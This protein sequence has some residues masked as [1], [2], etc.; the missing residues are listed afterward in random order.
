MLSLETLSSEA[1][2]VNRG[3]NIFRGGTKVMEKNFSAIMAR[4]RQSELLIRKKG[5]KKFIYHG[6]DRRKK[7]ILCVPE[8]VHSSIKVRLDVNAELTVKSKKE[9]SI[10]VSNFIGATLICDENVKKIYIINDYF[11]ESP[12]GVIKCSQDYKV[13]VDEI[14]KDLKIQRGNWGEQVGLEGVK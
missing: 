2:R 5:V 12:R 13:F 8:R 4:I 11:Q 3:C 10:F 1:P 6:L 9:I 14:Y 7:D